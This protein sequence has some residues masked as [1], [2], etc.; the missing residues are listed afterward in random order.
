MVLGPVEMT[1]LAVYQ[2]ISNTCSRRKVLTCWALVLIQ[3]AWC[4]GGPG[5]IQRLRWPGAL[6]VMN[7]LRAMKALFGEPRQ[8]VLML[9][10]WPHH[11]QL[12]APKTGVDSHSSLPPQ[13]QPQ[14]SGGSSDR[15]SCVAYHRRSPSGSL[16][17][18]SLRVLLSISTSFCI[19][20]DKDT[21]DRWPPTSFI[22]P[23][24]NS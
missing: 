3:A 11:H 6:G 20:T 19:I 2:Y 16:R 10:L 7:T 23:I 22:S 9:T 5:T 8:S 13:T 14:T 18:S 15:S 21:T 4:G 12:F 17:T 1:W 24:I